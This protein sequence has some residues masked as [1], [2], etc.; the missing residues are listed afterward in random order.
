MYEIESSGGIVGFV[1]AAAGA[2]M[3]PTFRIPESCCATTSTGMLLPVEATAPVPGESR[4]T[5]SACTLLRKMK[6]VSSAKFP[7]PS[8]ARPMTWMS[9]P[10]PEFAGNTRCTGSVTLLRV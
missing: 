9:P 4:N 8:V 6:I 7:A 1:A 10:A 3:K 2:T 5:L